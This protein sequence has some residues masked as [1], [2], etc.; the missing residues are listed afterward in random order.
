M[1]ELGSATG[2]AGRSLVPE[3]VVLVAV[4][5]QERLMPAIDAGA[6]VLERTLLLLRL[7]RVL[8]LPVVLTTQY[9]RGLGDL[10]SDVREAAPGVEPIDK[11][12]F[13]CFGEPAF[14][15]RLASI[16]RPQ[17][18]V[19]GVEAHICVMQ[20]VLGALR[21]GYDVHVVADAVGARSAASVETGL[22]RVAMAGAVVSNTEMALYELL[23]RSDVPAFKQMLPYLKR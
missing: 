4:D 16:G 5:I 12:S 3:H 1:Q 19:C 20:T 7:S 18:L 15:T 21:A 2:S 17:L 6:Q 13:G 10:V 22:R 9:R 8:A 11:T 14:C 23:G